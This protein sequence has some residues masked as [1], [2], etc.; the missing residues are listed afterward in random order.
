MWKGA[1]QGHNADSNVA[2][3]TLEDTCLLFWRQPASEIRGTNSEMQIHVSVSS[4]FDCRTQS[5]SY[6]KSS[7]SAVSLNWEILAALNLKILYSSEVGKCFAFTSFL[8][9][10]VFLL[11][12]CITP[13][14]QLLLAYSEH[15]L[16]FCLLC[17]RQRCF[18]NKK[19]AWLPSSQNLKNWLYT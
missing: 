10:W 13:S 8:L 19:L 17:F 14:P 3:K 4:Q 7:V 16:F 5:D 11:M 12:N 15:P 18:R 1:V 6:T 2:S 9:S